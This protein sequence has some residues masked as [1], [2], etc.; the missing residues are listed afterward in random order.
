[1]TAERWQRLKSLFDRA[2][3]LDGTRQDRFIR[4]VGMEDPALEVSLRSLIGHHDSAATLLNGPLIS[5]ERILEYLVAGVRTFQAGEIVGS[6]FRIDR[7]IGEGG[8]GEVYAAEDL[9]LGEKVALKTLRPALSADQQLL[10]RFKGEIQIARK[11]THPNVCRVFD[12]FWHRIESEEGEQSIAF[13]TMELLEGETLE[14]H[15]QD[16]GPLSEAEALPLVEQIVSGLS[17]AHAAG[18]VHR[19]FKSGNIILVPQAAGTRAAITDFGLARRAEPSD[20]GTSGA[21]GRVEGTLAYAAPEQIEGKPATPASDIY[22]LGVVLFEM[23]TGK[24]PFPQTSSWESARRLRDRPPSPKALTPKLSPRWETAINACLQLDPLARPASAADVLKR[25]GR[26]HPSRRT[27]AAAAVGC[28]ALAAAAQYR[29]RIFSFRD[30]SLQGEA[31][32]AFKRGEEFAQRR[33]QDGLNNAVQEFRRVIS[34][35]PRYAPAWIGLADA[36]SAMSN[37][38]LMDPHQALIEAK[39]AAAQAI[40]IDG[41]LA[42]AQGIYG[43]IISL[44]VHEWLKAEPYFRRAVSLDPKDAPIRLW[45]G[46]Y[47]GKLGRARDA[48]EQL[49]AGLE[50]TPSSMPLNH[51]LAAELFWERRF[52]EFLDQAR[53]LVRLQP[54]EAGSHLVLARAL[55][56]LGR[57]S[58]AL[59]SCD[60]ADR[61]KSSEAGSCYRAS[62][63]AASGEKI[64][65]RRIAE[66]LRQYWREKPFETALLAS[67]FAKIDAF[68]DAMEILIGG[69]ER[70]DSTVLTIACSPYFDRFR[71]ESKFKEFLRRIGLGGR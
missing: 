62:I 48:T 38:N 51:Q 1:M 4:E 16:N 52:A 61:L 3:A 15:L 69:Y 11:V 64:E 65:A 22:A 50:Q 7:F 2:A 54:Y 19:D 10:Q 56:W 14:Q 30:E 66:R 41:R 5:Q 45:Y 53:E 59:S 60:E 57:Y 31:L 46:A 28:V 27:I 36:Y 33:N 13:L 9:E 12:L 6:R 34:L 47:L 29:F 32:L 42:K 63:L 71:N 39:R 44:D 55:E 17:A 24:L 58:E 18:I 70:E 37:Y 35:Q 21:T 68:D 26:A 8:M 49:H 43:R 67:L 23:V 40:A 20:A 25:I